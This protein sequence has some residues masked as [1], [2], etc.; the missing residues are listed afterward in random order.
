MSQLVAM[1]FPGE[2]QASEGIRILKDL[3]T[4][5]SI[6]LDGLGVVEKDAAGRSQARRV[7]DGGPIGTAVAALIG[8]VAGL[9]VGPAGAVIGAVGG[10]LIGREADLIDRDDR[11]G[12]RQQI[13]AQ[14][15]P[16][17]VALV[18]E[19]TENGPSS[20]AVRM[21]AVGGAI[22]HGELAEHLTRPVTTGH[23][24]DPVEEANRES[25][26]ASDPPAW[27][28]VTGVRRDLAN[29]KRPNSPIGSWDFPP[30]ERQGR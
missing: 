23:A 24:P 19:I 26:P 15:R 29:P 25:F 14:L 13:T 5:G 21:Q 2:A 6:A 16:G 20:L 1:V 8:A 30:P 11:K 12:F 27:T 28:G 10:A 4:D 7:A 17:E 9:A 18:A 22:V 3:Q